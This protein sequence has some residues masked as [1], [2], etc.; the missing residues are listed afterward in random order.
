MMLIVD[1]YQSLASPGRSTT[2]DYTGR[3]EEDYLSDIISKSHRVT[4]STF[5]V[6]IDEH[7]SAFFS[8][9]ACVHTAW[10]NLRV[11][12]LTDDSLDTCRFRLGYNS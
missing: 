6:L 8:S 7:W 12:L 5:Q 2:D 4:N 11:S 10:N 1:Q 9:C 3:T